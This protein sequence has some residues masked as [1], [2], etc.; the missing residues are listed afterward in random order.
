[1]IP[2]VG[3]GRM[4][5][6][7]VAVGAGVVRALTI[8]AGR[9]TT[10][11][12]G[13][14]R[15]TAIGVRRAAAKTVSVPKSEDNLAWEQRD[16]KTYK[17]SDDF[18]HNVFTSSILLV[19]FRWFTL[20][21]RLGARRRLRMWMGERHGVRAGRLRRPKAIRW[22]GWVKLPIGEDQVV[23][24]SL[25]VVEINRMKQ[26]G[27]LIFGPDPDLHEHSLVDICQ[28]IGCRCAYHAGLAD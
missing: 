21:R 25:R 6:S 19:R 15:A 1:M 11:G 17:S 10:V 16:H 9:A 22:D 28:H 18:F 20:C 24:Q 13:M 2:I 12:I 23:A 4:I 8:L 5:R 27:Q 3:S 7:A 26:P 14:G